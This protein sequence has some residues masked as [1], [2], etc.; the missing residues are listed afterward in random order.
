MPGSPGYIPGL[1]ARTGAEFFLKNIV[2]EVSIFC[3]SDTNGGELWPN[4]FRIFS[5]QSSAICHRGR[6]VRHF[7]DECWSK[8]EGRSFSKRTGRVMALSE[9]QRSSVS[10]GSKESSEEL[11]KWV[12]PW[13]GTYEGG[14]QK[15]AAFSQRINTVAINHTK[16]TT[17]QQFYKQS[18]RTN[19]HA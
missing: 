13:L 10:T 16:G 5:I 3:R 2:S 9:S 6:F 18:T 19:T 1:G 7:G 14:K 11:G 12:Y 15:T 17:I 4:R 8:V